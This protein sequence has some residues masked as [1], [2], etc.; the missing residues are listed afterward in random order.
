MGEFYEELRGTQSF[1]KM[2]SFMASEAQ[3]NAPQSIRGAFGA[4]EVQNVCHGS[5]NGQAATRE[6]DFFFGPGSKRFAQ[7]AVLDNCTLAIIKPH[8]LSQGLGGQIVDD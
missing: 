3:K 2:V 5:A 1:G 7:T 4:N 8:A 6:I